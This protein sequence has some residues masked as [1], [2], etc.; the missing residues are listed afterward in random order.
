MITL[1]FTLTEQ[2]NWSCGYCDFPSLKERRVASIKDVKKW[3]EFAILEGNGFISGVTLVGGELGLLPKGYMKE[4][5]H[6]LQTVHMQ[7]APRAALPVYLPTNGKL[8]GNFWHEDYPML[9]TLVI[10]HWAPEIDGMGLTPVEGMDLSRTV[11]TFVVHHENVGIVKKFLRMNPD[12]D[13]VPTVYFS[14]S[15]CN[16]QKYNLTQEDF[17]TLKDALDSCPNVLGFTRETVHAALT[18]TPEEWESLNAICGATQGMKD[19]DLVNGRI[20]KCCLSYT[21]GPEV[22]LTEENFRKHV[23]NSEP[24]LGDGD[25]CQG[26]RWIASPVPII[27]IVQEKNPDVYDKYAE[28]IPNLRKKCEAIQSSHILLPDATLKDKYSMRVG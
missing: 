27:D 15:S 18:F 25:K 8:F 3:L 6:H 19:I 22:P 24:I 16:A 26:C 17:V 20:K 11:L 10:W 5:L 23:F 9:D 4:V 1:P 7:R 13:F 28:V 12:F 14:K 2:C 21:E